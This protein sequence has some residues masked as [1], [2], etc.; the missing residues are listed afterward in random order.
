MFRDL[1]S[2]DEV[3]KLPTETSLTKK[4]FSAST[5]LKKVEPLSVTWRMEIQ[6][7]RALTKKVITTRK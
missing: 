3:R 6:P 1:D 5:E 7:T 4:Y 2:E